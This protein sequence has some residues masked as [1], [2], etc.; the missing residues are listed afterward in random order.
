MFRSLTLLCLCL[1]TSTAVVTAFVAQPMQPLLDRHRSVAAQFTVNKNIVVPSP[2]ERRMSESTGWDSFRDMK[3]M[4]NVPSGEEQRMY[5]R[6]VYTHDDWK[7]HRSQDRFFYYLLAIFKSGVYKNL[8]REVWTVTLIATF[9]V[10]YNA[11]TQG[12]QDLSGV[13]QAA[14][15]QTQFLPKLTLPLTAFTVTSP[16]L[17]LLLGKL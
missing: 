4:T 2:L 10:L 7:K 9:V 1:C 11:V 8:G 14:L 6:T 13:T 5:R 15:I 3:K 16:S 12:Y 17:G